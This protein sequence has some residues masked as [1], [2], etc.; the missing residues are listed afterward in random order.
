MV[1]TVFDDVDNVG[2]I[3]HRRTSPLVE[4]Y[5]SNS[6][7]LR[8]VEQSDAVDNVR[9]AGILID[10]PPP[11]CVTVFWTWPPLPV[12]AI[13]DIVAFTSPGQ[14]VEF[15]LPDCPDA[16]VNVLL[17]LYPEHVAP[18]EFTQ[19]RKIPKIA[20]IGFY[21]YIKLTATIEAVALDVSVWPKA[22]VPHI[23]IPE[24]NA[25]PNGKSS[26]IPAPFAVAFGTMYS[27]FKFVAE[28]HPLNPAPAL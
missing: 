21:L 13:S 26:T 23:A 15:E 24:E 4:V 28:L 25:P 1:I 27:N 12:T 6:Q 3:N 16:H 2:I 11:D 7:P 18:N 5:V 9:S 17:K 19:I 14:F 8:T 10:A 22:P 20:F